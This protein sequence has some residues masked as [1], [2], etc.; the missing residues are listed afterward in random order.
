MGKNRA[1]LMNANGKLINK[2][3]PREGKQGWKRNGGRLM[4]GIAVFFNGSGSNS[5]PKIR[6]VLRERKR[7]KQPGRGRWKRK[8]SKRQRELHWRQ[9]GRKLPHRPRLLRHCCAG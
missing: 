1:R 8:K 7:L 3:R 6:E 2:K 4:Y 5:L 9:S